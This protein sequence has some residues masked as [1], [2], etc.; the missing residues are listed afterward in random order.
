MSPRSVIWNCVFFLVVGP[1]VL[2]G[3]IEEAPAASDG[4]S[5]R[6]RLSVIRPGDPVAGEYEK[7]GTIDQILAIP[8]TR[9]SA[10]SDLRP[11][12][13][14]GPE[15]WEGN[16]GVRAERNSLLTEFFGSQS[17]LEDFG[18]DWLRLALASSYKGGAYHRALSI[19]DT[20][21]E[22]FQV[23]RLAVDP[24]GLYS[25]FEIQVDRSKY[26]LRLVGMRGDKEVELYFSRVGLGSTEFPTPR[27]RF[28]ITR[29]FD[30]RPL[31]IPPLDRPWALGHTPSHS[32]YGGHM[33]PFFTKKALKQMEGEDSAPERIASKMEMVDSGAYRV[34]GTDSPWSVGSAQS[35]GCVRMLNKSV[36]ALADN[37]KIY[38]GTT[39]RGVSPNGPY[40]NLARPV[41]LVLY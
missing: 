18:R 34:H 40:V 15:V 12:S 16:R 8:L 33:M 19:L 28:Y 5:P 24:R 27:G 11:G 3:G 30:D 38:V 41:K 36:K 6:M 23:G 13:G 22:F 1:W 7:L 4:F 17:L 39:S 29:I 31:W 37:L 10:G 21:R 25:S 20:D 9:H 26:T 2:F 35:H 32:V 14:S